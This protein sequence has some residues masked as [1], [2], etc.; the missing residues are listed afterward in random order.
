MVR[1]KFLEIIHT[2]RYT[3]ISICLFPVELYVSGNIEQL[4]KNGKSPTVVKFRSLVCA[5][6]GLLNLAV[7]LGW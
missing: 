4:W 3:V 1:S 6:V 5:F 7:C 2:Y